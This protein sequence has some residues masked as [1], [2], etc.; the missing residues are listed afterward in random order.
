MIQTLPPDTSQKALAESIGIG[1][2]TGVLRTLISI[3]I[4]LRD[5]LESEKVAVEER[6]R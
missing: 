2:S 4:K 1:A 6:A 5:R 3:R